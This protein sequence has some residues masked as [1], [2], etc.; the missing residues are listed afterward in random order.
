M[1]IRKL[2]PEARTV[3]AHGQMDPEKLEEIILDFI[4]GQYDVLI[5]TA[6]IESGIDISNAN[7]IFIN[8]AHHFGLSDLHQLRGRVGRSNKKAFCYLLTPPV[9]TLTSE[10]RRRLKAIEDF[11]ELGSGFSIAM[12]D[13]DIRGAGNLLGAEQS[14][15]IAEIGYE[16]YQR[17]LNEA[18]QELKE[19]DFKDLFYNEKTETQI[20]QP[21]SNVLNNVMYITDCQI[22]TDLEILIPEVYVESITERIKLYR[23]LDNLQTDEDLAAFVSRLADRFGPVPQSCT[24]LIDV[25]RLRRMALQLGF[26]RIVL[27]NKQMVIYFIANQKSPYYQ[28]PV[29]IGVLNAVNKNPKV[30]R[31]KES[32]DKL[33]MSVDN[34]SKVG[35]AIDV[36]RKLNMD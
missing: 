1:V 2:V 21:S 28:S 8:D 29:F 26:E 36:I 14:G 31:M 10:A 24:D 19:S 23:E 16:T 17:I 25:V 5:A 12:Q 7:T 30:F 20:A 22:D 32:K 13:L 11:S 27:K 4:D 33:I 6:I 15:F 9:T 18:I 35:Q 3:I 34:I